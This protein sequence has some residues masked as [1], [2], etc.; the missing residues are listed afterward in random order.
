MMEIREGQRTETFDRVHYERAKN[1][2][3]S[4][5]YQ[6]EG[7]PVYMYN[8]NYSM[9]VCSSVLT[10]HALTSNTYVIIDAKYV[11]LESLDLI[12]HCPCD[13]DLWINEVED[14]SKLSTLCMIVYHAYMC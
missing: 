3:F 11:H 1:R 9:Q 7:E 2:S 12:N 14:Y 6:K 8:K 5:V 10:A 13:Y 4:L